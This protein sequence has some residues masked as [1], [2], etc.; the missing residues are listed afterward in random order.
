[1]NAIELPVDVE[2]RLHDRDDITAIERKLH[3]S[4]VARDR[5]HRKM[6]DPDLPLPAL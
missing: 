5:T 4:I 2:Q 1:V 6:T 3:L